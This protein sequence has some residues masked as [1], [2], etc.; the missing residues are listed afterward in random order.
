MNEQASFA[1]FT[2]PVRWH[3]QQYPFLPFFSSSRH[4]LHCV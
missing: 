2:T 3:W 1:Y 4:R